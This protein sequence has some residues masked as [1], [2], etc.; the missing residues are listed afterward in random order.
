MRNEY[1]RLA[2][3]GAAIMAGLILVIGFMPC[4]AKAQERTFALYSKIDEKSAALVR[5]SWALP[6]ASERKQ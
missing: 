5:R 4:P 6:K 2:I 3:W 1:K